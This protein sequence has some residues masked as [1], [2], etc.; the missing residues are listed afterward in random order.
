VRVATEEEDV[1][2]GGDGGVG[3][4]ENKWWFEAVEGS[5]KGIE[6]GPWISDRWECSCHLFHL[7]HVKE[8]A[9][10]NSLSIMCTLMFVVWNV[11]STFILQLN[12][13]FLVF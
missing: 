6:T 5:G 1:G 11:F 10:M 12:I 9:Q 8:G 3:R 13:L 2:S 4:R 7:L